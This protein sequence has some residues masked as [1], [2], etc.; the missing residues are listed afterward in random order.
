MIES[1]LLYSG[2]PNQSKAK[3][4]TIQTA[5]FLDEILIPLTQLANNNHI[6]IF[7]KQQ[8]LPQQIITDSNA[9]RM[10]LENL[11]MNCIIHGQSEKTASKIWFTISIKDNDYLLIEVQD[12]GTGI[13]KKEQK[14]VFKA[15]V[16][17]KKSEQNQHPGSGLGLNLIKRMVDVLSGSITL[18]SPYINSLGLKENGTQFTVTLPIKFPATQINDAT[19][20]QPQSNKPDQT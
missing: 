15:F 4:D 14:Q 2:M 13:A 11:I 17:G 3:E 16:R 7:N 20:K 8:A 1:T 18:N 5:E 19:I 6:E 12:N 9:L 10:I